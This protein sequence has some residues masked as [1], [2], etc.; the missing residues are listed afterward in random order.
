MQN[1]KPNG[2]NR[3]H[4]DS[5][6]VDYFSKDRDWKQHFLSLYNALVVLVDGQFILMIEHQSTI[7]PGIWFPWPDPEFYVF[8]TGDQKLPPESYLY[9]SDAFPNQVQNADLTLLIPRN[10]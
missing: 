10:K 1:E 9:L 4:K 5:L 2:E 3:K 7:N 6:F 8:Y